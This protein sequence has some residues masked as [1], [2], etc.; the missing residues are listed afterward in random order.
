MRA[1]THFLVFHLVELADKFLLVG[2]GKHRVRGRKQTIIF[3][4]YVF[5]QEPHILAG[6]LTEPNLG[7]AIALLGC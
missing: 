3:L 4:M 7:S 2:R 5:G 1:S 6:M